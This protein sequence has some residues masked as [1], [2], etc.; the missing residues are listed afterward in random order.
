MDELLTCS[1][2]MMYFPFFKENYPLPGIVDNL[3]KLSNKELRCACCLMGTAL[4]A[5]SRKK[6]IWG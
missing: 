4:I 2:Q 3:N 1:C 6:M 5:I